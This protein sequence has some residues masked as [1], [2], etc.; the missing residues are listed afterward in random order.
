MAHGFSYEDAWNMGYRDYRRYSLI[1]AA[2]S[3]PP[4]ERE[5][6]VRVGTR[7]DQDLLL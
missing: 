4:E 3:I 5:E 1:A 2:W 6:S 7:A